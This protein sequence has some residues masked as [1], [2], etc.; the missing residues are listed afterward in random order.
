MAGKEK[1]KKLY[2]DA[3]A[4]LGYSPFYQGQAVQ[5]LETD[6]STWKFYSRHIFGTP[7][8]KRLGHIIVAILLV[9]GFLC[10]FFVDF[11]YKVLPYTMGSLMI[12]IGVSSLFCAIITKEYKR[13][14]TKLSSAG[15]LLIVIGIS[16]I[17]H[18]NRA[19]GLIGV[20]WGIFGMV[21]GTESLNVA[22]YNLTHKKKWVADMLQTILQITLAL[23]LLID[24][25]TKLY[26]HMRILGMEHI[27]LAIQIMRL[28]E[29]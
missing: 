27:A 18:G 13:L 8:S 22:I 10:L 14:D 28:N 29:A 19:D 11:I 7:L 1:N 20:I 26:P 12:A 2:T 6:M 16:I 15:I 24:P 5:E 17:V 3:H 21:E 4:D 25:V 23:L 9:V